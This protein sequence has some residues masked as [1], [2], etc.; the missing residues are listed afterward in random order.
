MP[1]LEE[2]YALRENI[3]HEAAE[4]WLWNESGWMQAE[5][6][7]GTLLVYGK[8]VCVE[9]DNALVELGRHGDRVR[10]ASAAAR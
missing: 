4:R 5:M 7:S 10:L 3:C 8:R 6:L 9:V 1:R 2:A